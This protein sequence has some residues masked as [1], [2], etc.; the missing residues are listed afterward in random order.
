MT[1]KAMELKTFCDTSQNTKMEVPRKNCRFSY[2]SEGAK[3]TSTLITIK[4]VTLRMLEC[5]L[6]SRE[7]SWRFPSTLQ[8]ILNLLLINLEKIL[9]KAIKNEI[10]CFDFG[11]IKTPLENNYS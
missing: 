11:S 3:C 1:R 6:Q 10:K 7:S 2:L 4:I 8:T 9:S 5:M